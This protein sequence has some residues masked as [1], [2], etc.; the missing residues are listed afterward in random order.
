MISI[1]RLER[2]AAEHAFQPATTERVIRLTD[3]LQRLAKDPV[4]GKATALKGGTALNLF[5]L[6]LDRLSVDID[7][8]YVASPDRETMLKDQKALNDRIPRLMR[9]WGYT[10]TR[11]ASSEHAGGKWRFRYNSA[12]GR[13]GTLEID[14]NYL[15]RSPFFGVHTLDS[16]DLGG[17]AAKNVQVVDL[18]EICA[19]KLVAFVARRA[20]RDL[21]DAWRLLH[22]E[23]IDWNLVKNAMC[24]IGAASRDLDWRNVSLDGYDYDLNDFQSKLLPCVKRGLIDDAGG[25]DAWCR[26]VLEECQDRLSGLYEPDENQMR[27]LDAVYEEGRLDAGLL[28]VPDEVR[29]HIEAFPALLWKCRNISEHAARNAPGPRL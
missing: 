22:T 5:Y 2:I 14:V 27:F 4:V 16:V 3:V 15:Y 20:S 7:L 28:D 29:V 21:F 8:N 24:A 1:E 19:G 25:A 6:G 9:S 26:R 11:D 17:Y 13:Q 18:H 10:V 12:Y 23:G